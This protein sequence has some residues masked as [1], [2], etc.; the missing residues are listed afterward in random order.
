MPE[1]TYRDAIA[2]A[3]RQEMRADERVFLLGEDIGA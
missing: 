1:M 2:E 3:L